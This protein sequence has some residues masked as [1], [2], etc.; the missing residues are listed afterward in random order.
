MVSK[1]RIRP[2]PKELTLE[3]KL[4]REKERVRKLKLTIAEQDGLPYRASSDGSERLLDLL[5]KEHPEKDPD[6]LK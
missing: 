6:K 1:A 5:R 4:A 2:K 3:E